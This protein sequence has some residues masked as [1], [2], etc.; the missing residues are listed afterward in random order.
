LSP[1]PPP[2]P[3]EKVSLPH[4]EEQALESAMRLAEEMMPAW[5]T[6][7]PRIQE[8]DV[9]VKQRLREAFV[10]CSETLSTK[11]AVLW[12]GGFTFP[13]NVK[14]RDTTALRDANGSIGELAAQAH[15]RHRQTRLNTERVRRVLGTNG[16]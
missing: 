10:A 13:F 16:S 3:P 9:R 15:E 11:D 7:H 5:T 4:D 1:L 2:K 14:N 8:A 12:S 6:G